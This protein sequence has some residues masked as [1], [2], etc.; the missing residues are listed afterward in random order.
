MSGETV[1]YVGL[2]TT[3]GVVGLRMVLLCRPPAKPPSQPLPLNTV[4]RH[5]IEYLR[6][7]TGN[8]IGLHLSMEADPE[9]GEAARPARAALGRRAKRELAGYDDVETSLA[10]WATRTLCGLPWWQMASHT[11]EIALVGDD[12]DYM[13]PA[14]TGAIGRGEGMVRKPNAST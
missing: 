1:E 14:C 13:C 7:A 12:P 10:R 6:V 4:R 3:V 9:A 5:G 2:V 11:F 8:G